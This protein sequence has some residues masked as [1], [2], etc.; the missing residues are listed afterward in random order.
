[1]ASRDRQIKKFFQR[2]LTDDKDSVVNARL[3]NL[4]TGA[5]KDASGKFYATL[6]SGQVVKV[7]NHVAPSQ[8]AWPVKLGK[9]QGSKVLQVIGTWDTFDSLPQPNIPAHS[10]TQQ[11]P[12]TDTLWVRGEQILPGLFVPYSGLTVQAYGFVYYSFGFHQLPNQQIDLSALVPLAGAMQ[13]LLEVDA[14]GVLHYKFGELAIGRE[15]LSPEDIPLP[16]IDRYPLVA[17]KVYAGQT[18]FLKDRLF[19]DFTDLRWTGF[20]SGA[21]S[22]LS[23]LWEDIIGSTAGVEAVIDGMGLEGDGYRFGAGGRL[24]VV[25]SVD[26]PLIVGRNTAIYQWWVYIENTGTAGSTIID[27][28]KDGVSVFTDPA[29]RP[30]IAFDDA[31]GKVLSVVANVVDY[32][33]GSIITCD[34]A[35]IATG[36]EGLS[37]VGSILV[38]VTVTSSSMSKVEGDPDPVF[39]YASSLPITFT[40]ALTREA[41]E[42][43]GSY[44]ILQG[45]L[46][47]PVG[48]TLIFISDLFWIAG[49]LTVSAVTVIDTYGA[50]PASNII[51]GNDTTQWVSNT[52]KPNGVWFKLD[53]GAGNWVFHRIRFLQATGLPGATSFKVETCNDVAP[54]DEFWEPLGTVTSIDVVDGEYTFN[55]VGGVGAG[56]YIKFTCLDGHTG[57]GW[58][59]LDVTVHGV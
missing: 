24:A 53:F 34:I 50:N 43:A 30:E 6:V 5:L 17:V 44:A 10:P 29:D 39:G 45:T 38:P 36:A 25:E 56:R 11:W 49:T 41:G 18:Q 55:G 23:I 33:V 12:G 19:S 58:E 47:A 35:Q 3:G 54:I 8:L 40:G 4:L 52:K 28:L 57:S 13:V 16:S 46:A 15:A 2:V 27:I 51:D 32:T 20:A 22:A 21:A 9:M 31:D 7:V 37:V 1:M 48:Y 59:V 42:T 14:S 26:T